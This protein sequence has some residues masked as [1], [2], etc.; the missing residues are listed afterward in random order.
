MNIEKILTNSDTF[1]EFLK[2][3]KLNP[4]EARA[5]WDEYWSKYEEEDNEYSDELE[6]DRI[7]EFE[8]TRGTDKP[9]KYF[10]EITN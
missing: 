6:R 8:T 9:N 10:P 1:Q 7:A 4:D 2:R 3:S 5:R